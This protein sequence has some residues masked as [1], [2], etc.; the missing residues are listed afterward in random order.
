[1]APQEKEKK[2][3]KPWLKNVGGKADRLPAPLCFFVFCDQNVTMR[4]TG[5]FQYK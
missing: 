2:K 5:R 3:K 1:M 4:G